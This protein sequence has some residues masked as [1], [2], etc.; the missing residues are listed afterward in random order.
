MDCA[1]FTYPGGQVPDCQ[2]KVFCAAT[3]TVSLPVIRA[4]CYAVYA[5]VNAVAAGGGIPFAMQ[6]S[7]TLPEG[8]EESMLSVTILMEARAISP[9]CTRL[10]NLY[11][12]TYSSISAISRAWSP[13]RSISEI[14]RSA[15]EIW[16]RS[17]AT[18]W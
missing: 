9:I 8:T 2:D 4:G 1:F 7:L 10:S 11:C 15:E 18:G 13:I 12:T 3:Q 5:A 14:I 6:M 16:R 17:R